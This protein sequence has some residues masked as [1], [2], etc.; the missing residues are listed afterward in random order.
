[1]NKTEFQAIKGSVGTRLDEKSALKRP[2]EEMASLAT[3]ISKIEKKTR[4]VMNRIGLYGIDDGDESGTSFCASLSTNTI[5]KADETI[6][7]DDVLNNVGGGFNPC[8]G[9]FSVPVS[10]KYLISVTARAQFHKQVSAEIVCNGKMLGRITSGNGGIDKATSSMTIAVETRRCDVIYVK[11]TTG[12]PG[13]YY[14]N[15]Y[16]TFSGFLFD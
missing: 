8:N 14:G 12:K 7:F 2:E 9:E 15:G 13:E 4:L 1:M 16:T 11:Q 10:G 6:M 5:F 3:R